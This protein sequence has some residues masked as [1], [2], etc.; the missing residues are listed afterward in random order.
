MRAAFL[1]LASAGCD[2]SDAREAGSEKSALDA[3]ADTAQPDT[4]GNEAS[5]MEPASPGCG[6]APPATGIS[7]QTIDV[8]GQGR[9]YVLAVPEGYDPE[10]AHAL[11]FVFHGL[12]D[13]AKNMQRAFAL[14]GAAGAEAIVVY[15]MGLPTSL[16]GAGWDLAIGGKDVKLFDTL[17]DAMTKSLCIDEG[18]VFSTGFSFGGFFSNALGCV[19]GDRLRAIAPISGSGPNATCTGKIAVWLTHGTADGIVPYASGES[20]RDFWTAANGCAATTA[21]A[22]PGN[23]VAFDGCEEAYPVHW[24]EHAGVHQPPPYAREGIWG[25]FSMLG[26]EEDE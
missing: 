3:A 9:D 1:A 24:C 4:G 21:P 23:C 6:K 26:P 10:K 7:D 18:R 16:G 12:G 8:G 5:A 15:P 14:E 2:D 11:V 19:R 13:S 22:S 20:T 25:F 17:R